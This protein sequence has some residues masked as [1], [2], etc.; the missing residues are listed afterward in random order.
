MLLGWNINIKDRRNSGSSGDVYW[1]LTHA[2]HCSTGFTFQWGLT[3][4]THCD[5]WHFTDEATEAHG[6]TGDLLR[7]TQAASSESGIW[8][9]EVWLQSSCFWLLWKGHLPKHQCSIWTLGMDYCHSKTILDRACPSA[10]IYLLLWSGLISFLSTSME[11]PCRVWVI[12]FFKIFLSMPWVIYDLQKKKKLTKRLPFN[13][14]PASLPTPLSK[15]GV[16]NK[17]L[18]IKLIQMIISLFL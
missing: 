15:N 14:L 8:T 4:A 7:V 16:Q 2:E 10:L 11:V 17:N 12:Y 9:Q 3:L 13:F 5:R 1:V 18:M 6:T